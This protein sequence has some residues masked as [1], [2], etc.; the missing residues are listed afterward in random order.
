MKVK[1]EDQYWSH[2][3]LR[4]DWICT[5]I[6]CRHIPSMW[7]ED[8]R[9][10]RVTI[11]VVVNLDVSSHQQ[12][13]LFLKTSTTVTTNSSSQ[14]DLLVNKV[15]RILV[16]FT[17]DEHWNKLSKNN[18]N[19]WCCN[20]TIWI[21]VLQTRKENDDHKLNENQSIYSR[22]WKQ[23]VFRIQSIDWKRI[24]DADSQIKLF[25]GWFI[26]EVGGVIVNR[27]A[28]SVINGPEMFSNIH[29][30]FFQCH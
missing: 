29:L 2:R 25:D 17:T 30:E 28:K 18:G 26:V 4:L 19:Q 5:V 12:V 27:L 7:H 20:K 9:I 15:L 11:V 23:D 3:Y 16:K 8:D 24:R 6:S 22:V 14:N 10:Q 21:G 13:R 1:R